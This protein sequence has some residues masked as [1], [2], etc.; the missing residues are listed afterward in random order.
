M[1]AVEITEEVVELW[2]R[3][4]PARTIGN[5]VGLSTKDADRIGA[6][7][8]RLKLDRQPT[9]HMDVSLMHL[10]YRTDD[11]LEYLGQAV[12]TTD[13]EALCEVAGLHEGGS[14]ARTL[15]IITKGRQRWVRFDAVDNLLVQFGLLTS[16]W[17]QEPTIGPLSGQQPVIEERA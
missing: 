7:L 8:H 6:K 13:H 17:Q 12:G 16:M 15:N 10:W 11:V 3:G 1:A 9:N 2:R 4:T 14:A 5:I